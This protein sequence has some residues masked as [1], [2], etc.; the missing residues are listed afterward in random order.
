MERREGRRWE[1]GR[2]VVFEKQV[3]VLAKATVTGTTANTQRVLSSVF[4]VWRI[5]I[6]GAP[7]TV[8]LATGGI[9]FVEGHKPGYLHR[10]WRRAC[11]YHRERAAIVDVCVVASLLICRND[12]RIL[13]R[14]KKT[15]PAQLYLPI[16]HL[17]S[18]DGPC[19]PC[20]NLSSRRRGWVS[21]V[22]LDLSLS[23]M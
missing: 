3:G 13:M 6:H 7:Y 4:H 11:L 5:L 17:F 20:L 8:A 22:R 14:A 19:A 10:D 16:A 12:A 21:W 18:V 23:H 1:V 2:V 15:R 9:A